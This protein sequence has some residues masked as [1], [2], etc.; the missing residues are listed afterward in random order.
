MHASRRAVQATA[1]R[2]SSPW[3]ALAG[4]SRGHSS[5]SPTTRSTTTRRS[6]C[7]SGSLSAGPPRPRPSRKGRRSMAVDFHNHLIPGVDDGAQTVEES[8]EALEC[9]RKDGVTVVVATPHVDASLTLEPAALGRRLAEIDAG[10]ALLQEAAV[11]DFPD[12]VLYRGCELALDVPK[13]DLT[14]ARL[15]LNGGRYVLIEF[16]F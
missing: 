9:F 7:S 3:R 14:D 13:P 1:S 6:P 8:L 4:S 10:W 11:R 12:I 16:P 5:R 15:R 2:T